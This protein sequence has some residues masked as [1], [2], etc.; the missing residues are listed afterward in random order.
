MVQERLGTLTGIDELSYDAKQV[1]L[2]SI[3]AMIVF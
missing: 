1:M 3:T 2:R